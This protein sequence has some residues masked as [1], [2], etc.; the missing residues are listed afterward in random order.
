[1]KIVKT[2]TMAGEV[3]YEGSIWELAGAARGLKVGEE[4]SF[5]IGTSE[6]VDILGGWYGIK[7]VNLFDNDNDIYL[8]GY[9]GGEGN[10]RM[11][12]MSEFD[13]VIGDTYRNLFE[14]SGKSLFPTDELK[15]RAVVARM[16]MKFAADFE[17]IGWGTVVW[18]TNNTKEG[19]RVAEAT[20]DYTGGGIYVYM[21]QMYSG[22]YFIASDACTRE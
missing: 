18:E 11:Y 10:V 15:E 3:R 19:R 20:A 4:L 6:E 1:M 12:Q 13:P 5:A 16:I 9:W 8:I 2:N 22:I 21:G 14:G 7:K 17:G